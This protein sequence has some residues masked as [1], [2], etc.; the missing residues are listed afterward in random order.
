G[1]DIGTRPVGTGPYRL[2][3]WKRGSRI[4]LEA[5]PNYRAIK[6]PASNDPAHAA[7]VQ[8]MQGKRLPQIGVVSISIMDEMQPPLTRVR[9][10]QAG[11][12]RTAR[13]DRKSSVERRQAEAAIRRERHPALPLAAEL[14]PLY[15]LQ[16]G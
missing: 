6:F 16:S 4:V 7:L 9:A 5:N 1:R 2:K 10:R 15:V 14:C 13:G 3:E 12:H 8:S 11:L